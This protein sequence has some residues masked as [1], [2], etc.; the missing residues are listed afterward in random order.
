MDSLTQILLGASVAEL[1]I[2]RAVGR[3]AAL[4]GAALG[5]L[6]DLDVLIRFGGAVE[7]FTYHR[8]FS[9]S[10]IVMT[11]IAPVIGWALWKLQ[12]LASL[13]QWMMISCS[14]EPS[15]SHKPQDHLDK[16]LSIGG[17]TTAVINKC[18]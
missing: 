12:G 3:R 2:G 15:N 11:A 6:P 7:D 9:H 8:G 16:F 4:Y 17:A 14:W 13:R 5:T 10:F 1:A 18:K